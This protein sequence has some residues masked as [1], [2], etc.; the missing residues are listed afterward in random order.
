MRLASAHSAAL[1]R[2]MGLFLIT[3]ALLLLNEGRIS[4]HQVGL[5]SYI[6]SRGIFFLSGQ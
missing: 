2:K 5:G 3:S 6:P 4:R 1:I